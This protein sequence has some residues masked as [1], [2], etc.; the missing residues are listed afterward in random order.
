MTMGESIQQARKKAKLSQKELGAR[1]GVS[2]SMI[3]QW[4]NNLRKP[5]PETLRKI[6]RALD[7][8]MW[9]IT[10]NRFSMDYNYGYLVG[11]EDERFIRRAFNYSYT[12]IEQNLID[13]FAALNDEGQI[14]AVERLAELTEVPKYKK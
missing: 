7:I 13:L 12:N 4:E 9:E 8:Q 2:A 1:I 10:G 5:K 14:K 11:M 6:A 3:G